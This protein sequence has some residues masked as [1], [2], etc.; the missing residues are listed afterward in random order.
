M[1]D[2]GFE[3]VARLDHADHGK[4]RK[5]RLVGTAAIGEEPADVAS[6]CTE[7]RPLS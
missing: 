6:D 1:S 7:F 2:D 4:I 3:I 5:A